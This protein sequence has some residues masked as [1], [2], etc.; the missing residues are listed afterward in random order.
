ML[1]R[2]SL[3]FT[4]DKS[5]SHRALML[6]ALTNGECIV[7]N[8]A[9][10]QDVETTRQCLAVCGI[11]STR[12]GNSIRIIGGTLI[13]PA[14]DLDCGNSGT[15]AR[16]LLG[17]LA[18][19]GITAR[20][21]GDDSL[22]KRPMGRV[23]TPL[24]QMGAKIESERGHL[25]LALHSRKLAGISYRPPVASAQ[26]KS[27]I[28]L[29]GLGAIGT[30][31]VSEN[32]P[33]RD[34]TEK[35]LMAIGAEIEIG[36]AHTALQRLDGEL[37]TFEMSVPGDP[38][39]AAFF[40]VAAAGLPDSELILKQVSLNPRRLGLY[41][42]L[43]RMGA[44]VVYLQTDQILGEPG[45]DIKIQSRPLQG[46]TITAQDIP[47]MID[48]LPVLAVLA[49]QAEGVTEI[50][51]AGE[52]RVKESDRISAL[53]QN[54]K[55]LGAQVEEHADG[56]TIAGPSRLKGGSVRSFGD[57]RIAM[58]MKIA[59]LFTTDPISIDGS[60]CIIISAPEFDDMLNQV[61]KR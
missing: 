55:R 46:V 39:T 37:Q 19:Q 27:A 22:S 31:T 45:G 12:E 5:I 10:G 18:G 41:S 30:T 33:T 1:I 42:M 60:A 50:S 25:P 54:L 3:T 35:M 53:Y 13:N 15:T 7:Y 6:A 23:I 9:Q 11:D 8:L 20:F 51:G 44:I 52:L 40:A 38:S 59:G 43:E 48:E 34:H 32:L 14:N 2:G 49:T 61:L 47:G 21:T 24:T 4:G 58:A 26:V 28:L 16:L 17:L 57:H 56:L 29:A 36:E